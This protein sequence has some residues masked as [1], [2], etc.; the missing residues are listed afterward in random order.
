MVKV[1][2]L[3]KPAL[4]KFS[5]RSHRALSDI[6]AAIGVILVMT[7][8]PNG[9][10]AG[11]APVVVAKV[12]QQDIAQ[13][14]L[15]TGTVT[16]A[17]AAHLS[18]S[19]AGLVSTLH[20]ETGDFVT[21]GQA[22]LELDP[23]LI[24]LQWRSSRAQA[25]EAEIALQDSERRLQEAKVLATQKNIAVTTV[26]DRESE[27]ASK[28]AALQR[29]LATAN[30]QQAL[31]ERHTL[32]APF[33]GV[34]ADRLTDLGEWVAPGQGVYAL[35]ATEALRLDF[36][37]AETYLGKIKQGGDVSFTVAGNPKR[38]YQG[39][40]QTIVPVTEPN[41][42]TFLLRVSLPGE[43]AAIASA[44]ADARLVA[45]DLLPGMSVQAKLLVPTGEKGLV[46]PRDA[47]LRYPDG[48]TVVWQVA[49]GEEGLVVQETPVKLGVSYDGFIQIT[50][51]L[52]A[53][54]EVV[55]Q[56]NEALRHGQAVKPVAQKSLVVK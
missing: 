23:E 49:P 27:V 20:V 13:E 55:V 40:V 9:L 28:K 45:A 29:A 50:G 7:L 3:I 12:E 34:I 2:S 33:S 52:K 31:L 53:G 39:K 6:F 51:A 41:A 46:V 43:A 16:S 56:G 22:L 21:V 5:E 48:R 14:V 54:A 17:K 15:L 24:E 1:S 37:V 11:A 32:R 18:L 4:H 42:R 8:G 30:Y 47:L 19:T 38:T 35:V 25:R 26:K 10:A 44:R 36:S